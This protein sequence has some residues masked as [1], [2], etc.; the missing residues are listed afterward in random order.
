VIN[1]FLICFAAGFSKA[2]VEMA[3]INI[4]VVSAIKKQSGVVPN[5]DFQISIIGR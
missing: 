2:K 5:S 1:N 4:V 3:A